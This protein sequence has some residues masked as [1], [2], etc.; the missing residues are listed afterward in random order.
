M[1]ENDPDNPQAP[2]FRE[3]LEQRPP[4]EE[5]LAALYSAFWEIAAGRQA[6][7]G[8]CGLPLSDILAYITMYDI[9][10]N[11]DLYSCANVYQWLGFIRQLDRAWVNAAIEKSEASAKK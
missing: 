2:E 5:G 7:M 8:P 11:A 4:L 1:V 3:I 10:A 6:A 9:P